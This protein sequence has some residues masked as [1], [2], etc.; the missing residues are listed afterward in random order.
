M[1][2]SQHSKFHSLQTQ[3]SQISPT[4]ESVYPFEAF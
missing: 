3:A 4:D 1:L 2:T